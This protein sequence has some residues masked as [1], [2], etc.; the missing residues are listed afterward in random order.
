[1]YI[2][3]PKR[4]KRRAMEH[5]MSGITIPTESL[6]DAYERGRA[7]ERKRCHDIAMAIDSGRGNEKLIA[8]AITASPMPPLGDSHRAKRL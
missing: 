6:H 7:E 1:M 8:A 2:E 4:T 3:V 5:Y